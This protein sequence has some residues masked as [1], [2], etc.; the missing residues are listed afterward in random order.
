MECEV[1]EGHNK[2]KKDEMYGL[3]DDH[4]QLR[5]KEVLEGLSSE[6][7]RKL[8]R[9]MAALDKGL[10]KKQPVSTN[11][12]QMNMEIK[13]VAVRNFKFE[14][15][16]VKQSFFEK[17]KKKE[18]T[19]YYELVTADIEEDIQFDFY[20]Y[21]FALFVIDFMKENGLGHQW[22]KILPPAM[23]T[24]MSYEFILDEEEMDWVK[25][26]PDPAWCLQIFND[27]K[28]LEGQALKHSENMHDAVT[29]LK[30]QWSE[31]YQIY[32]DYSELR[33][34]EIR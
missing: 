7:K 22:N 25:N 27:V 30:H 16:P 8:G 23:D 24:S 33:W 17:L 5:Q 3:I 14:E 19:V 9:I 26:L 15:Q 11:E 31:G 32:I 28:D 34:L 21:G 10:S 13:L 1:R 20:T 2:L 4:F 18:Q 12:S 29:W 6:E